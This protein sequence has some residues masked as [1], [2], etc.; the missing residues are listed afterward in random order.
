MVLRF[1]HPWPDRRIE[2]LHQIRHRRGDIGHRESDEPAGNRFPLDLP[3]FALRDISVSHLAE[4]LPQGVD[5]PVCVWLPDEDGVFTVEIFDVVDVTPLIGRRVRRGAFMV[6]QDELMLG[7]HTIID[8][9]LCLPASV[10][11]CTER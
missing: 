6:V 4:D 5:N 8:G 11:V 2:A 1:R 7:T 10:M 3:C 9:H